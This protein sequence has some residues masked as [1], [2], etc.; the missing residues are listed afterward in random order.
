MDKDDISFPFTYEK[1]PIDEVVKALISDPKQLLF[2]KDRFERYQQGVIDMMA[3]YEETIQ[4]L[5]LELL[6]ERLQNEAL[7]EDLDDGQENQNNL[8]VIYSE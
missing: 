6:N 1:V 7:K 3:K 4:R 5:E 2:A 8:N